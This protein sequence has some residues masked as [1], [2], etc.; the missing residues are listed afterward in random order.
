M[1]CQFI[2]NYISKILLYD[3]ICLY[4]YKIFYLLIVYVPRQSAQIFFFNYHYYYLF[5]G[6]F[7]KIKLK[8]L[9]ML[10]NSF[11]KD[12]LVISFNC[13]IGK[14]RKKQK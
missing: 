5:G 12:K 2:S 13:F 10:K 11:N 14:V 7:V 8:D 6:K 1:S 9:F 4:R 3:E